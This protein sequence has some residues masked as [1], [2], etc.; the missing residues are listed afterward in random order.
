MLD[1][2]TNFF[3]ASAGAS[4]AF[5]GLLFVAITVVNLEKADARTSARINALAGSSF[6]LLIDTFFVAVIGLA[7]G[8]TSF[9][10]SN[11]VMALFGLFVTSQL[12]PAVIRAG[13][14]GRE[15][16]HRYRNIAL[17]VASITVYLSQI[18]FGIVV[19]VLPSST[20][21]VRVLVLLSLGLYAGALAR[22][23]EIMSGTPR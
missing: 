20:V 21:L 23:W 11:V 8:V 3:I 4:A 9:A 2:F 16:P 6:A 18:V 17:P 12:L 19:F 7:L 14:F 22:A 15:A 10:I 1:T 5:I 13:N